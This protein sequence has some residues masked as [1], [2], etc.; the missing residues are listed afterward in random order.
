M[1]YYS[2]NIKNFQYLI[3]KW[4]F[5]FGFK[6]TEQSSPFLYYCFLKVGA[7]YFLLWNISSILKHYKFY[8][9][10]L[11]RFLVFIWNH[12]E[13]FHKTI[14]AFLLIFAEV[15]LILEYEFKISLSFVYSLLSPYPHRVKM[16]FFMQ[17]N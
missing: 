2:S 17:H 11:S 7:W 9:I 13:V 15:S 12:M 1:K 5:Y 6:L 16:L 3:I 8:M 14:Q 10:N 4:L